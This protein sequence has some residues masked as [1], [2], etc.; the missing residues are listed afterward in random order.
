MKTFSAIGSL[1]RNFLIPLGLSMKQLRHE[2]ASALCQCFAL[3]AVILPIMLLFGLKNGIIKN[4]WERLRNDPDAL[5][6]L[7]N[8]LTSPSVT[9]PKL[10]EIADRRGV[11]CVVPQPFE[12]SVTLHLPGEKPSDDSP[13]CQL[14]FTQEGDPTIAYYQDC[15][16]PTFRPGKPVQE[17]VLS[18]QAAEALGIKHPGKIVNLTKGKVNVSL[19]VVGI[20]PEENKSRDLSNKRRVFIHKELGFAILDFAE[21][22]IDDLTQGALAHPLPACG[23][24]LLLGNEQTKIT[25]EQML[26]QAQACLKEAEI[27]GTVELAQ[28]PGGKA[29]PL[30]PHATLLTF[31]GR[32]LTGAR[33]VNHILPALAQKLGEAVGVYPW[34]TELPFANMMGDADTST[35]SSPWND[36]GLLRELTQRQSATHCTLYTG[37]GE[38][39]GGAPDFSRAESSGLCEIRLW[40]LDGSEQKDSVA[41][42]EIVKVPGLPVN[43][44]HYLCSPHDLSLLAFSQVGKL[45]Y[46]WKFSDPQTS[47]FYLRERRYMFRCYAKSID[48]VEVLKKD[49]EAMPPMDNKRFRMISAAEDIAKNRTLDTNLKRLLLIISTLGGTGA[50][51]ALLFNLFNATERRKKDYAILRTLGL[52]RVA[53]ITLPV[54]ETV[55][56]MLLTLA[57]SL[58]C[59]HGVN[60][61]VMSQLSDLVPAG[62]TL[63]E[64]SL[65]EQ[66][67]FAVI[68]LTLA[69][70]AAILSS[71]RLSRLSPAAYIRES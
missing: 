51:I 66:L 15:P 49:L 30:P 56:V 57:V 32:D 50:I 11:Q 54:Y 6:M 68:T 48:D 62:G 42:V 37:T 16:L 70:T 63:C 17:A 71:L 27:T 29:T 21:G 47:T 19:R 14:V 8:V 25:P 43:P 64:L 22:L 13:A 18:F 69:T 10:Q 53:L 23:Q 45:A 44:P 1:R 5:T 35:A 2:W 38:G 31:K 41:D 60:L 58:G 24:L 7:P 59:F 55:I 33:L 65:R 46:H 9:L 40:A 39:E 61:L 28:T 3:A 4:E 34:N 36:A 26:A 12:S 67:L 20:L 52:G